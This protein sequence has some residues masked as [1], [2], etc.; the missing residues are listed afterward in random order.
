MLTCLA[1]VSGWW[2]GAA[3]PISVAGSMQIYTTRPL[4]GGGAAPDDR[5]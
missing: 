2:V 5:S 1:L 4:P 3:L